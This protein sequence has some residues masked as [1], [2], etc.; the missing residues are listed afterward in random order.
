MKKLSIS[1]KSIWNIAKYFIAAIPIIWVFKRLDFS[2]FLQTFPQIAWWTIPL[3]IV[4]LL[5]SITLQ[6]VRWWMMLR[7]LVPDLSFKK[8]IAYHYIGLFYSIALPAGNVAQDVVKSLL[9]SQKIGYGTVWGATW[10]CRI[11]GLIALALLSLYG[12]FSI[13]ASVLPKGFVPAVIIA[14]CV[15]ALLVVVSFSKRITRPFRSLI[16]KITPKKFLQIPQT[17]RDGIYNYRDKKSE[18]FTVFL[19]TIV[20]QFSMIMGSCFLV[21]G[22]SGRFCFAEM[23]AFIPIIEVISMSVPITPNGMGIREILTALMFK[24][25]GLS[26]ET[27][28]VYVVIIL[29][30]TVAIRLVG[31]VFVVHGMVKN[32][33]VKKNI[34]DDGRGS[35]P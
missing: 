29:F 4:S 14:F 17:I 6:G 31:G 32:R 28:G 7:S 19:V 24:Q 34:S 30:F 12:L 23:L 8:T 25:I 15:C 26:N 21:W 11:L 27:L 16:E 3:L 22:I 13:P 20:T 2:D 18:L 35:A 1:K 5:T 10:I 33:S 9:L